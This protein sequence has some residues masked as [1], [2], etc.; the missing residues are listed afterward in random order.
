M[1]SNAISHCCKTPVL[2][3]GEPTYKLQTTLVTPFAYSKNFSVEKFTTGPNITVVHKDS[4]QML[5]EV[6]RA[7]N[8]S[9]VERKVKSC[10]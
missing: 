4:A 6:E 1:D 9:C 10:L 2:G 3:G 7:G 8:G 5:S